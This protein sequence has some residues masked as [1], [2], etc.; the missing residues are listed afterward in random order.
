LSLVTGITVKEKTEG[1]IIADQFKAQINMVNSKSYFPKYEVE[2]I[3]LREKQFELWRMEKDNRFKVPHDL[4]KFTPSGAS[5]C[6]RELF[7][8][9]LRME[10]DEVQNRPFNNRWTRNSTA[11]HGA[12]QRDILYTPYLLPNPNFTI[13]FTD[14]F[15]DQFGLLPAWEKNIET[16]KKLE[17]NGVEFYVSGMMDGLLNHTKSGKTYGFEFKTKTND[18]W[19]VHKMNKPSPA[20]VQ[21]CVA[22]S[23]LFE[24]SEGNPVNDYLLTYE[25]VPKDKWGSG[26]TALEDIKV[27]HVEVTER[28]KNSLK[29]KWSEVARMVA[30]GELPK[31]ETS[32]CLFCPYKT[33]CLGGK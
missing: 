21:Q 17:H 27:F 33:I 20:H 18:S 19:Q 5:K 25:A 8:K 29:K 31:Q 12:I 16:Y 10:Q 7:Y 24:D 9:A 6:K 1:E 11:I 14:S 28:Q 4:V 26:T 30:D 3:L 13:H 23:L 22:Y 32:K 15:K 2:E